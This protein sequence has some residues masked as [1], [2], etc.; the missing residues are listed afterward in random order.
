MKHLN[1]NYDFPVVTSQERKALINTVT[2]VKKTG[3]MVFQ[4]EYEDGPEPALCG[5]W[6]HAT[7]ICTD[8]R[9]KLTGESR[10]VGGDWHGTEKS[11]K[12]KQLRL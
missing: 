2:G 6:K 3:E 10:A 9:M 7:G 12:Q 11:R 8:G 5:L 4:V 1:E